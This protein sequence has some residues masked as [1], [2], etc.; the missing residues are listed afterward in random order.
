MNKVNHMQKLEGYQNPDKIYESPRSLV[1]RAI[2]EKKN[3]PVILKILNKQYPT[4]EENLKFNRE[5]E[6]ARLFENEG[7]IRVYEISKIDN[8]PVIIME[9][10]DG[11]TLAEILSSTILSPEEFLTLAVEITEIIEN[12]HKR[13]IIHKD[14]NPTNII[15]NTEKNITRIIDFGIATELP[16]EITSVKNANV[17]EGTVAYISPEQT[18]RMNR[19]LDYRTDFYSLGVTFY[20]MITG[21]LPFE[22]KDLLKQVHSHIAVQAVSPHKIDNSIPAAI[23]GIIMKLMDKN[24]EDRYQSAHGLK[25]D[26]ERCRRELQNSGAISPFP[27]G[28]HD[29]SDKFQIPQKLYGREPELK[30]LMAAFERVRTNDTELMLV[31]G[32]SGIGKSVLVNEIQKPAVQHRGYF[33]SGKFERRKKDMPYSAIIQAFSGLARQILAEG[34]ENISRWKEKILSVLGLNGT[35]V[36]GIIPLFELI[37]GKQPDVP[38]VGPVEFQNRFNL[39]F[40]AF[41]NIFAGK[42]H[43][44]VVF[45]DDLQWADAASLHLLKLFTTDFDVQHLFMIGAYR[46]DETPDSH[47]LMRTL[48]EIEKTGRAVNNI[49]LEALDLEHVSKL[50]ADTLNRSSKETRAPA[51]LL[52]KKTGGN[53]FFINE[54]LKSLYNESLIEFSFEH[55]WSWDMTGIA[56]TQATKNIVAIVAIKIIDLPLHS[57]DVLKQGA[58]I[59]SSFDLTTLAAVC[60]KPEKDILPALKDALREG[61]LNKIDTT[62]KFSHDRIQEAAYALIPDVDKKKL[63]YRIGSLELQNTKNTKLPEK[64]FFIVNQLNAGLELITEGLEKQKLAE[65]NL[66]A[67]E[68]ALASG[69]YSSALNYLETGIGLLPENAWLVNYDFTLKLYGEAAIAAGLSAEYADMEELAETVVNNARTIPETIKAYEAKIA[70]CMAQNQ[71]L[72][73]VRIGLQVLK[74]LGVRMPEKP[75][76]LR[77]VCELLLV[78]ISLIGKPVE[79]LGALPERVNPKQHAAMR[80]VSGIASSAYYAAPELFPLLILNNVRSSVR[81]GNTTYSPYFYAGF[82]MIHCGILGDLSAGYKWGKLALDLI[83]KYNIKEIKARVGFV[84]WFMINHWKRPLRDSIQPLFEAYAAGMDTGDLEFAALNA[85]DYSLCSFYSGMELVGVEKEMAKYTEIIGKLNQ[86]TVLNYQRMHHQAVL[87]LRGKSPDPCSLN[88]SAYDANTM[89]PVHKKANDLAALFVVY[90]HLSHLNYLFANYKEALKYLELAKPSMDAVASLPWV[91]L[92]YFYDSLIR[93]ALFQKK[94]LKTVRKNQKKIKKWTFHAPM[95]YSHK[96]HLVEAEIARVRGEELKAIQ[97]YARAI[98]LA[99]E[100][101]FLHE[102]ALALELTA[103]F[104]WGLNDEG[105]AAYYMEKAH[106]TYRVWGAVAKAKHIEQKYGYLFSLHTEGTASSSKTITTDGT[107][108]SETIDLST[109]LKTSQTL[110]SEIDLGRLLETFMK[111]SIENA[112]AQRGLLLIE[113]ETNKNLYIEAEGETNKTIT[114]LKSIP[115]DNTTISS[116][117]VAYVNRTGESVVLHNAHQEGAF[118]NDPYIIS[119]KIKSLLCSPITHKGKV[120]GILYLENNL[121]V[122]TFTPE[123]LELLRILFSQAAISIENARLMVYRENAAKLEKEMEIAANIQTGLLPQKPFIK[124]YEI[125]AYLKPA[126]D[127][128]GDYYDVINVDDRDWIVIGDVSGHGVPAG[129]IMM[130]AQTAIHTAITQNPDLP[131]SELLKIINTVLKENITRM[132]EDKYMTITVFAAHKKGE[133]LFSGLHQDILIFRADSNSIELVTT[134]GMWMGMFDAVQE[135][136]TDERLFLN[137]GDAMLVYTDGITEAWRKGSIKDKREASTDMF[138]MKRLTDIFGTYGNEPIEEIK[139]KILKELEGYDCY[140]DVTMVLVRRLR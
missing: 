67:G 11:R 40:Q 88:G 41:I 15:R 42:E 135:N 48:D 63:H 106:H 121:S 126:D 21:R 61:M 50:L 38:S 57:Q 92:F 123:R 96:Y 124:N 58:C 28:E 66:L 108:T 33:I 115:I 133:F 36:T 132:N 16:R 76:T 7:V 75:G 13:N 5:F 45:L 83:E 86:D 62:Y 81:Y 34:E 101:K 137:T 114:V 44:L 59:G 98:K 46:H 139:N 112:G 60:G 51:E 99:N 52:I 109:V 113:S 6:L 72:E 53:P 82:G 89:L 110:S 65:L 80:I 103:K 71:L 32:F 94:D 19:S 35:I 17:L 119:N 31:S 1:Y 26:L 78:K 118:T 116:A 29:V 134:H 111:S 47:P 138:G 20:W 8:S 69:A 23:S 68:K 39:V 27:P 130:M 125:T 117:I 18:G 140:D 49:F 129:L 93:I 56:K 90:F 55:G 43:P 105:L 95:N 91:S 64:I 74:K 131:P 102:E 70:A 107:R 9:D 22:S 12:I 4:P 104:W 77:I 54:F 100:N 84:V 127:V 122:N 128:G 2:D 14:I 79:T 3:R 136:L 37:I 10:I 120:S 97:H 87:N 85:L 24:A 30:S 73:G 25:A